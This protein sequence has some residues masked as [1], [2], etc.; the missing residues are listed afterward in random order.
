MENGKYPIHVAIKY[1]MMIF[2][3]IV[4]LTRLLLFDIIL[5]QP[6]FQIMTHDLRVMKSLQFIDKGK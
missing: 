5:A 2:G 6:P 1:M 4:N 3:P